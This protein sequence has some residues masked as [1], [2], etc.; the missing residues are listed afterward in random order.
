MHPVKYYLSY[1]CCDISILCNHAFVQKSKRIWCALPQIS[2]IRPFLDNSKSLKF[3]GQFKDVDVRGNSY[4]YTLCLAINTVCTQS[5]SQTTKTTSNLLVDCGI[6]STV[7]VFSC[8]TNAIKR[9]TTIYRSIEIIIPLVWTHTCISGEYF[10]ISHCL[11]L[12]PAVSFV[13]FLLER[14]IN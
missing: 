11:V 4:C 12:S 1:C 6:V 2:I 9:T 13:F 5:L 3:F 10:T 8:M 14:Y 7:V